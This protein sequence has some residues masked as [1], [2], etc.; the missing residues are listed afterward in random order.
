MSG[1]GRGGRNA[2]NARGNGNGEVPNFA[3]M[4]RMMTETITTTM[5][6]QTTAIL[7]VIQNQNGNQNAPPPPPGGNMNGDNQQGGEAQTEWLNLLEKFIRLKPPVF[8]GS[9]DP[10]VVD[11]WK[12]DI[13]KIFVAMRCT[14]VQR[15]QLAI[16]QLSGQARKWWK[17]ASVGLDLDTLTY[18]QFCERFDVRYF[19]ATVRNNKIKEFVEVAQLRGD[20]VDDYLDKYIS[21][22]R[23]TL[24]MIP[25]EE[26]SARKFEQGLGDHIHN[27]VVSHC[28]PT[29]QR[30]V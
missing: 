11:K 29:F 21:L 10:L 30:V 22:S 25:D 4:M 19:P 9:P 13:D 6:N 5:T 28:F 20:L 17:N 7:A 12:E 23:F 16:F 14:P 26:K 1:R 24:F 2:S 15:Q 27:K 8:E 3:D 18:S